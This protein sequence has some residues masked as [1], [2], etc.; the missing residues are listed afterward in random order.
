MLYYK[1]QILKKNS[2]KIDLLS[3]ILPD[4]IVAI[5]FGLINY[6]GKSVSICSYSTRSD[7]FTNR[8]FSVPYRNHAKSTF[9]HGTRKTSVREKVDART[10]LSNII[11]HI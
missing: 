8:T 2:I 6:N 4:V 10:V 1:F 3:Y 7:F 5:I 11:R 9:R